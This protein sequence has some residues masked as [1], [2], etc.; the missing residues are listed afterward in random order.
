MTASKHGIILKSFERSK[1]VESFINFIKSIIPYLPTLVVIYAIVKLLSS[2]LSVVAKV[3]STLVMLALC[4][5]AVMYLAS[6]M[7]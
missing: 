1:I 6:M 5:W 3:I 2:G 4:Y 7:L